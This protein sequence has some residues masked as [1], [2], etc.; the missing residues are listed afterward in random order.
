MSYQ[1]DYSGERPA[2]AGDNSPPPH[3]AHHHAA[4][5]RPRRRFIIPSIVKT[6]ATF[7]VAGGLFFGMEAYAPPEWRPS[8]FTGTYNASVHAAVKAAELQQQAKNDEWAASVKVAAD[9]QVEQYKAVTQTVLTNYTAAVDRAKIFADATAKIQSQFVAGRIAQA[10]ASQSTDQSVVNLTRLWGRFAN[11]LEPGAGDSALD[12]SKGL[13][14]Q[15]S[16]ELTD[17]AANGQTISVEG[18][19]TGLPSLQEQQALLTNIKPMVIPPPPRFGDDG[20]AH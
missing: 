15:L 10:Q 13:S 6:A 11:A 8:R 4:A 1:M 18:W 7:A 5:Y 14:E 12:Y 19:N 2:Q 9:Q 20:M 17:A 16:S 3:Y